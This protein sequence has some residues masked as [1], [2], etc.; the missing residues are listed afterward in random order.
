[1][2]A[3]DSGLRDEL[4]SLN[5]RMLELCGLE[6]PNQDDRAA[7]F[8]FRDELRPRYQAVLLHGSAESGKDLVFTVARAHRIRTLLSSLVRG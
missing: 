1:M 8:K 5:H 2:T 3:T 4:A 6:I 7:L